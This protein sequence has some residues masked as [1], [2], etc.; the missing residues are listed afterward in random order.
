[1]TS[2]VP[3]SGT[4]GTE[5]APGN[6]V[7]GDF[8]FSVL[9]T[10]LAEALTGS[11]SFSGIPNLPGA[12]PLFAQ[13]EIDNSGS[14]IDVLNG[15][16]IE[17]F[18]AVTGDSDGQI[19][20]DDLDNP[21]TLYVK[22]DH[23]LNVIDFDTKDND[24]LL[25]NANIIIDGFADSFGIFRVPTDQKFN[26]NQGTILI[27]DTSMGIGHW[28]VMFFSD[29]DEE[30]SVFE[31]NDT[32]FNGI[33]FWTLGDGA[34][35]NVNNS[36]GCVQYVGDKLNFQNIRYTGCHTPRIG[37]P[38]SAPLPSAVWMGFVLLGGLSAVRL[39]VWKRRRAA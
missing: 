27:A 11:P 39:V 26:I 33:A 13:L 12:G 25:D 30:T 14:F 37:V 28:N 17:L 15:S 38:S 22:L 10:A 5:L 29:T 31:F 19:K 3:N 24:L 34:G 23:G 1:M 18:D 32:I 8:E 20:E 35:S 21:T 9:R 4:P 2:H 36:Q 7:T 6:G 16:T